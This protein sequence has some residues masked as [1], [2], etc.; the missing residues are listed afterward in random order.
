MRKYLLITNIAVSILMLTACSEDDNSPK[1]NAQ[2]LRLVPYIQEM[3]ETRSSGS[4]FFDTDDKITLS[5]KHLGQTI[6]AELTYKYDKN[7]TFK[8]ID[9]KNTYRFFVDDSH[10]ELFTATWPA[11]ADTWTPDQRLDKDFKYCDRLSADLTTVM[12]SDAALPVEFKHLYSKMIFELAG[13]NANGQVMT[14]LIVDMGSV[15]YRAHLNVQTGNAELIVKPGTLSLTGDQLI[16]RVSVGG[17]TG[18]ILFAET[19]NYTLLPAS[20]Y[21]VTLT[22][23]GDNLIAGI[24]IGGWG[25]D[26]EGIGVPL[27]K[28][29]DGYFLITTFAQ[30]TT[31]AD[32]IR[33]YSQD[34]NNTILWTNLKYRLTAS[35]DCGSIAWTP[36]EGFTG[37]FDYQ[38]HAVTQ[39]GLPVVLFGTTSTGTIE[40][41]P[42]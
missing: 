41:Q 24:S 39:N 29:A 10:I 28:D 25:Q 38:S 14:D 1:D 6:P 5:V 4:T 13:Q 30:L 42:L 2:E 11:G 32:L 15:A 9:D 3:N 7:G 35:L 26:E 12:P 17:F 33:H 22:P 40:N 27:T 34:A 23:R 31:V 21:T 36:I 16:G 18:S 20:C 19:K 8:G 37:T